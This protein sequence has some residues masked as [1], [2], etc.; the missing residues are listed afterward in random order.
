MIHRKGGL[1]VHDN[2]TLSKLSVWSIDL[3]IRYRSGE[4]HSVVH[5][6]NL[7]A[8]SGPTASVTSLATHG[9]TTRAP[10]A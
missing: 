5:G 4:N 8:P 7:T 3:V 2:S 9:F 6:I 10:T 1:P